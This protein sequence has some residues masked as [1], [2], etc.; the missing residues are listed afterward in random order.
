MAKM[1][2]GDLTPKLG[3]IKTEVQMVLVG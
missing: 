1:G 3:H 2:S